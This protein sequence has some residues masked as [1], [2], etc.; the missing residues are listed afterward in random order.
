MRRDYV[1]HNL[2]VSE[3]LADELLK[4][5]DHARRSY[6][7]QHFHCSIDDPYL[8]D[9]VINTD[10]ISDDAVVDL[11]VSTLQQLHC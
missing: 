8:Y 4:R 11:I 9:L 10:R 3:H 5:E 1:I 2:G 6:L 7:K